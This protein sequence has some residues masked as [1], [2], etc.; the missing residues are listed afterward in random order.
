MTSLLKKK[1]TQDRAKTVL[2]FII[3]GIKDKYPVMTY[4]LN[5]LELK[6]MEG[7][8]SNISTDGQH[9]LYSPEKVLEHYEKKE[10]HKLK[11]QIMHVL[12][13]GILG[14][15]E[16]DLL[17]KDR[18]LL[19]SVM[20]LEVTHLLN[21]LSE[22]YDDNLYAD[23]G[24]YLAGRK[25][26]ETRGINA[27]YLARKDIKECLRLKDHAK[28]WASDDHRLW[29]QG[30]EKKVVQTMWATARSMFGEN[31][32]DANDILEVMTGGKAR[33][34]FFYGSGSNGDSMSITASEENSNSYYHVLRNFF[35]VKEEQKEIPD[36]IDPMLYQYGLD[37]YGDIPLIEP[38][39]TEECLKLNTI[40]IG[41]DSSGSCSGETASDFMRETMNLFRDIRN[42]STKCAVY[43]F[44][45]DDE[46]QQEEY[47]ESLDQIREEDFGNM[48]LRGWGGTSFVPVFKRI[49]KIQEETDAEID[50]LIYL[51][52]SY[53]DCEEE[54]PDYPVFFV[55][56]KDQVYEDGS[57][58]HY[59]L[60]EWIQFVGLEGATK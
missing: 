3:N 24:I 21:T 41:L 49:K 59:D 48:E 25:M 55:L 6:E 36:A 47:F 52:D 45:C 16:M 39:E 38:P 54:E 50:C 13:H 1:E 10:F 12:L 28:I 20:D 19:W 53:G 7:K 43:L 14:H 37:L 56:P 8:N 4:A 15:L 2:T 17:Y 60:P 58:E 18:A 26:L 9:L 40:C 57:L 23:A 5:M 51:T 29:N 32:K 46:I 30:C 31:I 42:I 27:Y 33:G 44:V 22:E 35:K 11:S 34:G